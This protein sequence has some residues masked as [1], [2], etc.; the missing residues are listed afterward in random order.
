[1][2]E[3]NLFTQ[4]EAAD[5]VGCYV[6]LV[7]GSTTHLRSR[8][9][10]GSKRSWCVEYVGDSGHSCW[11]NVDKQ[12]GRSPTDIAEVLEWPAAECESMPTP[13]KQDTASAIRH[14]CNELANFLVGKNQAYGNSA[15][16]PTRIFAKGMTADAQLRVRIDDKLNRILKGSEFPGDDD[17]L[18][19]T[20][21]MVL[22]MVHRHLTGEE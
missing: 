17:L 20:G 22:L 19:L 13:E 21:Y 3:R 18:D 4:E 8:C 7:D 9:D 16:E 2:P 1:M 14:T 15:L 6:R 10:E 12:V 5:L 11:A